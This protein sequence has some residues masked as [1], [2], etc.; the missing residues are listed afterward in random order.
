[1]PYEN[2]WEH[3]GV[4]RTYHGD[5]ISGE[6]LNSN[7]SIQSDPRFS[8]IRYILNDFSKIRSCEASIEDINAIAAIDYGSSQ[9]RHIPSKIAI[10]ASNESLLKWI[11]IYFEKMKNSP[12]IFKLF[13]TTEEAYRWVAELMPVKQED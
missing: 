7:A 11:Q 13:D 8:D 5:I 3:R 10:V 4:L 2:I 12:Y 1:M 9:A 6:I